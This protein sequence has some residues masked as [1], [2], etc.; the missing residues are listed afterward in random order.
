M[1]RRHLSVGHTP[2]MQRGQ[3]DRRRAAEQQIFDLNRQMF[4]GR[5]PAKKHDETHVWGGVEHAEHRDER[6]ALR[7]SEQAIIWSVLLYMHQDGLHRLLDAFDLHSA[8]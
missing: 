2:Y 7:E 8:Q 6:G 1:L 4:H 3:A 5:V